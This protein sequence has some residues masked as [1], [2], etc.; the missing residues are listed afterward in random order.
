MQEH[1]HQ[2]TQRAVEAYH[3]LIARDLARAQQQLEELIERQKQ[4]HVLFGDRPLAMC[5][6]PVFL[7]ERLYTKVQDS[8]YLLRQAIL[9]IAAAH[10][11]DRD[12]LLNDLG[13]EDWEIEL[14]AIPTD[15]IRL[16]ATARMDSFLTRRSFRFVE[17]NGEVP[18]GAAYVHHLGRIYRELEIFQEFENQFPVRFVSPLEHLLANLIRVYHEEFDGRE[19]KPSFAIVDFLDIP[20]YPEFVL[21]KD[22]F[23]KNGF[24]CEICDPRHIEVRNGW[25]F[26][27]NRKIDILY[28]RL[29][30]N[31]FYE[32]KD[33]C[34]PYLAGYRA[35]KTCY[36]NS[37]RS[38]LVHKKAI[39][40]LLTDERFHAVLNL[41]QKRA[42]E[43]HI[44]WT[45]RVRERTTQ[46]RGLEIDLLEFVR[47]NRRYFVIKPN[48]SYGGKGVLLGF[49]CTQSEWEDR[50]ELSLQE[51]FV[52]QEAVNIH[53]E[54]FL[55][56]GPEGW[57]LRQ[58]VIDLDP[59]INGPLMGGCLTRI[60]ASNL[61]NV[62]AGGGTLPCF[63]L[64]YE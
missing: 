30:M 18:A 2:R 32:I 48:D 19:E 40:A 7:T 23:E 8:V 14:A 20:T 31:E 3:Q 13:M 53:R 1:L 34:K 39:L 57:D 42:I 62:T 5:L 17:V 50:L 35:Q 21:I 52:V 36:L 29:L 25:V 16:S 9:R 64:R 46:F 58:A 6:R 22:Y 45:R 4:N 60:S 47:A 11:N 15:V 49:D 37:F 24:P 44:P 12:V 28:R 10:F 55:M 54:P 61:A 38:K 33:D 63:I 59:Y 51:G 27:N 41:Q 56:S 43:D 26:A